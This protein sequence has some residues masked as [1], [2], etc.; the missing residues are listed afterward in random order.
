VLPVSSRQAT[1]A[2]FERKVPLPD[3]PGPEVRVDSAGNRGT[4]T[5]RQ[6]CRS[7]AAHLEQLL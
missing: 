2:P 3:A 5:D 4:R 7:M 1:G 6:C